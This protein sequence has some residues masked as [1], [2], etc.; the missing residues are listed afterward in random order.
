MLILHK[1][2]TNEKRRVVEIP[3]RARELKLC[4]CGTRPAK[5][6]ASSNGTEASAFLL[7][8]PFWALHP[9][10]RDGCWL[11]R[12]PAGPQGDLSLILTC[13]DPRKQKLIFSKLGQP[14]LMSVEQ[15][16]S[17]LAEFV[18]PSRAKILPGWRR[19]Q[20]QCFG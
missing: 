15:Q 10:W 13:A 20:E 1:Y 11:A 6:P 8:L 3:F 19:E 7:M 2:C 5:L 14:H 18:P 17:P 9:F 16:C 4:K 12:G